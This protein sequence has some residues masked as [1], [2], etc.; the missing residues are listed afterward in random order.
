MKT[1]LILQ[2]IPVI[3]AIG[4]LLGSLMKT[5]RIPR[6]LEIPSIRL[7]TARLIRTVHRPIATVLVDVGLDMAPGHDLVTSSDGICPF[8]K[9]A[10]DADLVAHVDEETRNAEEDLPSRGSTGRAFEGVHHHAGII[11]RRG[12]GDGCVQAFPTKDMIA[13]QT[14]GFD[15][16]TVADRAHEM[17]VVF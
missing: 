15:K 17:F 8:G 12:G 13:V 11:E 10:L 6:I 14:D 1:Y 3:T 7:L 9:R 16:R 4:T 2:L 5:P